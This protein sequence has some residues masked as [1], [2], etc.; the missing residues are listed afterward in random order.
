MVHVPKADDMARGPDLH[1]DG[2]L[3]L[4]I[5]LGL[6]WQGVGVPWNAGWHVASP[7]IRMFAHSSFSIAAGLNCHRAV[8]ITR[9]RA[10]SVFKLP[11]HAAERKTT[12][13]GLCRT[14]WAKKGKGHKE[15]VISSVL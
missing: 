12:E 2:I 5:W 3:I 14:A 1:I 6:E 10:H 9:V 4:R 13:N 15:P 7:G 11:T 8:P